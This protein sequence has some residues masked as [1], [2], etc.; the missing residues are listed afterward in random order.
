MPTSSIFSKILFLVFLSAFAFASEILLFK[1]FSKSSLTEQNLTGYLMS[2]KLDGVRGL[3]DGV[4][5][6]TRQ[7]HPIKTPA[8]FTESFPPF[9]LDGELYMGRGSFDD[10]SAL[11]RSKE[12]KE[13]LWQKVSYNVFDV[14]RACEEFKLSPCSLQKRLSVLE[15]YLAKHPSPFIKIIPQIPINSKIQ[16]E[17]F[18]QGII[19]NG[20]EGVIVRKNLSPYEKGRSDNALK[21]KPFEDAECRVVGYT[22]GRGKFAGKIGALLCEMPNGK[23]IKIGSGLKDK[24]RSDPP[25]INSIITYKFNGLTKNS[26]PRF[27]VFLRIRHLPQIEQ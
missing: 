24:D 21:L 5:L 10:I 17:N 2:E 13:E 4:V 7:N 27:P 16:L 14:P 6:K 12:G 23:T 20:G 3:W 8:F 9:A 22:E 18:Y 15:D 25:P 1:D 11:V 19:Q 26:L